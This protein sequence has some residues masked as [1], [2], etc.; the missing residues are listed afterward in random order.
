MTDAINTGV[1]VYAKM[2]KNVWEASDDTIYDKNGG[3]D[4]DNTILKDTRK[5]M[6][7]RK[8]EM[9]KGQMT[10]KDEQKNKEQSAKKAEEQASKTTTRKLKNQGVKK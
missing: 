4:K 10:Q 2:V 9:E 3:K 5:E 1:N 7:E 6:K 8:A